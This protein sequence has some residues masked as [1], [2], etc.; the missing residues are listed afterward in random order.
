A[1]VRNTESFV[2]VKVR[3]IAAEF[4]WCSDAHQC[5]HIG[6]VDIHLAANRMNHVAQLGDTFFKHAVGGGVGHHNAG[7]LLAVNINFGS[8]INKVDVAFVVATYNHDFEI[9]H[10]R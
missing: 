5:V 9:N 3:D 7:D 4:S 10:L 1:A 6:T 8:Q 2:Q